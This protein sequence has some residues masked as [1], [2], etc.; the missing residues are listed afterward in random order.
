MCYIVV[1]KFLWSLTEQAK[2]SEQFRRMCGKES[3]MSK[4][5]FSDLLKQLGWSDSMA[6]KYYGYVMCCVFV[7]PSV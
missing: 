3:L 5:I 1:Y 6:E 4:T 2:I 7:Q